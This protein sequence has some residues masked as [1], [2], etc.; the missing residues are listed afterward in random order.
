MLGQRSLPEG[1]GAD[2]PGFR[3]GVPE[4]AEGCD[5]PEVRR[6]VS[7]CREL[8][9]SAGSNPFYLSCRKAAELL[10][11]GRDKAHRWLFM[12]MNDRLL[13]EVCKSDFRTKRARRY[14][15]LGE[16]SNGQTG[17]EKPS[18]AHKKQPFRQMRSEA[19]VWFA[20]GALLACAVAHGTRHM[21]RRVR[22]GRFV[23]G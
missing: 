8:Q 19:I 10:G 4:A 18:I 20:L 11:V 6:L 17:A 13:E 1:G 3:P 5:Q 9:R 2:G 21:S 14:R 12:L 23:S 22:S 7:L 16:M 15:Y